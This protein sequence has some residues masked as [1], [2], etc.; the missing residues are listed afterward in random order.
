MLATMTSASASAS[1]ERPALR[2]DADRRLLLGVCA[3]LARMLDT[4]PW[5]VRAGVIVL[6]LFTG[7]LAVVAYVAAAAIVPRDDGRML[8]GGD[9]PDTRENVLGWAAIVLA[10]S[11]LLAA[12]PSFDLIWVDGW[13]RVVIDVVAIGA[14]VVVLAR[15]N[16]DRTVQNRMRVAGD[17][18]SAFAT[19]G[20]STV[21]AD[22]APTEATAPAATAPAATA[23]TAIVRSSVVS[24]PATR[25]APTRAPGGPGGPEHPTA[26]QPPPTPAP[27]PRGRSIFFPVAGA[28]LAAAGAIVALQALGAFDVDARTAAIMLGAGAAVSGVT[29]AVAAGRRGTGAILTVG[30]LLALGAAGVAA[31]DDELDGGVGQRVARPATAADIR[32]E[33]RLGVGQIDLDLRDTELPVGP[34]TT[35]NADVGVGEVLLRVAPDVRVEAVGDSDVSGDLDPLVTR[36]G[37]AAPIVR[38]DAHTDIGSVRVER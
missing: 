11:M 8:L 9:P 32:P 17:G 27:E 12:A 35:V 25:V 6:G 2:R 30:I 13:L 19:A 34:P 37:K 7:P 16:R 3:G 20:S 33:Y 15:A 28:L 24:P 4:E 10:C 23:E 14:G 18:G 26:V 31:A 21:A 38:L 29:A 22:D 36:D 5:I 1:A